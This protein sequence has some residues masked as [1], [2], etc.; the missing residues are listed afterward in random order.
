MR[1]CGGKWMLSGVLLM[2]LCFLAAPAARADVIIEEGVNG[3]PA[4]FN[5]DNFFSFDDATDIGTLT[6]T[7]QIKG[8]VTLND[9]QDVVQFVV[10]PGVSITDII[11]S[12]NNSGTGADLQATV[13]FRQTGGSEISTAVGATGTSVWNDLVDLGLTPPLTAGTTYLLGVHNDSIYD[14]DYTLTLVAPNPA[15]GLLLVCGLL[16]VLPFG[17][18][19][20]TSEMWRSAV[21]HTKTEA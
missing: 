6:T 15:T 5:F 9:Q 4:D 8:T 16:A 18:R 13:A 12:G 7:T 3:Q 10:A 14:L 19:R 11:L 2:V 21:G 20:R 1:R 17:R